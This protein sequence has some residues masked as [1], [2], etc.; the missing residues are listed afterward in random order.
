[1]GVSKEGRGARREQVKTKRR[2]T[3]VNVNATR[4]PITAMR[5]NLLGWIYGSGSPDKYR[6][7]VECTVHIAP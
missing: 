6:A 4:A 7:A 5:T 2:K 1:M 3:F